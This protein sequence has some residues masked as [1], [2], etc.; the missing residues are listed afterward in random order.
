[1]CNEIFSLLFVIWDFQTLNITRA[2]EYIID[3]AIESFYN[4]EFPNIKYNID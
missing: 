2:K 3:C 4:L 1:M